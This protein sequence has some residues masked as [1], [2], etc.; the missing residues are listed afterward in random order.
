MNRQETLGI[1]AILKTAYPHFYRDI[2]K[3]MAQE[4]LELWASLFADDPVEAVAVGVKA[5]IARD[6]K[7]FPPVPG[8]I[9]AHMRAV[10]AEKQLGELEA[11]GRVKKALR[12]SYYD[13]KR[14]FD[15]L[16]PL[17]QRV[18]G[19]PSQLRDWCQMDIDTLDILVG[20]AFVR[21]YRGAVQQAQSIAALPAA[22]LEKIGARKDILQGG[23]KKAPA[24]P[25]EGGKL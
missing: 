24:I 10:S 7:G 6:E 14:E 5:F 12:N 8:Q 2:S 25:A 13:A 3:Q 11:W 4:T 23:L 18:V 22:A 17:V 16:P 15:A 9:K 20:N 19:S 21:E 1:L